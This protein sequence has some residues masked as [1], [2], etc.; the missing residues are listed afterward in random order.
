M[1][2]ASIVTKQGVVLLIGLEPENLEKM[3]ERK[4]LLI[5]RAGETGLDAIL[6]G[7]PLVGVA[8]V[9]GTKADVKAQLLEA[10]LFRDSTVELYEGPPE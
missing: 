2:R 6:Q 7:R 1:I 4:P 8:I 5:R 10:G 3:A 9:T